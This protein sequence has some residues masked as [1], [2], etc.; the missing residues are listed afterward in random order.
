[1]SEGKEE[2]REEEKVG[3]FSVCEGG[4]GEGKRKR[5]GTLCLREKICVCE[6]GDERRV[7]GK[8]EGLCV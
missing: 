1:M 7:E 6:G 5:G 3:E 8:G 4:R 2:R